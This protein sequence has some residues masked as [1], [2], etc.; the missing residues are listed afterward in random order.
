MTKGTIAGGA[1]ATMVVFLALGAVR[2]ALE[3]DVTPPRRNV[4][5]KDPLDRGGP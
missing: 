5:R 4:A 1:F 2:W 3:Q